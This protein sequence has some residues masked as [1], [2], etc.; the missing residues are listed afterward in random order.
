MKLCFLSIVPWTWL[1]HATCVASSYSPV[2]GPMQF[3]G[4]IGWISSLKLGWARFAKI[5]LSARYCGVCARLIFT[6]LHCNY[7]FKL[8]ILWRLN[9]KFLWVHSKFQQNERT[10]GRRGMERYGEYAAEF[11]PWSSKLI[12]EYSKALNSCLSLFYEPRNWTWCATFSLWKLW[13]LGNT[14]G[15]S[16]GGVLGPCAP[17]IHS[18]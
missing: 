15:G 18:L 14:I 10:P 12:A 6:L 9:S 17:P 1:I 5:L 16:K 8:Y 4:K 11:Q 13:G 2:T 7:L 3:L